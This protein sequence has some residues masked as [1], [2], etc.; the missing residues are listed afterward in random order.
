[1][2]LIKIKDD[3]MLTPSFALTATERVLPKDVEHNGTAWQ[4][5]AFGSL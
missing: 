4:L 1:M 3:E 2:E 5:M